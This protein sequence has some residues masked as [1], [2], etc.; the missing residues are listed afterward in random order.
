MLGYA[1][2]KVGV[3]FGDVGT[4]THREQ[5]NNEGEDKYNEKKRSH[6]E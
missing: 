4:P 5:S 3:K 6:Y 2:L 1:V